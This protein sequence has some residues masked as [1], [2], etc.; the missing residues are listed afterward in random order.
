MLREEDSSGKNEELYTTEFLAVA[1]RTLTAT[2]PFGGCFDYQTAVMSSI[3]NMLISCK[4]RGLQSDGHFF[5]ENNCYYAKLTLKSMRYKCSAKYLTVA[6][7]IIYRCSA[8]NPRCFQTLFVDVITIV[9]PTLAAS[10]WMLKEQQ[11]QGHR[12]NSQYRTPWGRDERWGLRRVG[13]TVERK[14]E[15]WS[16]LPNPL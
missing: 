4:S 13:A 8:L 14:P 15:P 3:N 7:N 16:P 9:V 2:K 1:F 10:C 11:Q 12:G 6:S 5:F